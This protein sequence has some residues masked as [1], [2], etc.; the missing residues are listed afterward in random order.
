M[1]EAK[2]FDL[3][4]KYLWLVI[5]FNTY[6]FKIEVLANHDVSWFEVA[7]TDL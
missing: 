3:E 4:I 2:T 1:K 6:N 5:K 7:M